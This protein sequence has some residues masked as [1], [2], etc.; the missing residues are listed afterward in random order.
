MI[1]TGIKGSVRREVSPEMT[2]AAVG[3]GSL[4]VLATPVLMTMAEQAA[5]ESLLPFLADGESTVGTRMDFRHDAPSPIGAV[6]V[7][8][9]ELVEVDRRRLV[10]RISA[11]DGSGEI[12]SGTHERFL[13]DSARFMSKAASRFRSR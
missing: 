12:G 2:A 6:A 10:F 1:E 7:C 5:A 9:T 3:S 13:V 11:R 4:E 8:E